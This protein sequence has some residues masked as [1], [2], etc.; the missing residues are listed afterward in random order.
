MRSKIFK[1][2]IAG[3]ATLAMAAQFAVVLPV[4]A[5]DSLYERGTTTAWS[6]ADLSDWTKTG[7]MAAPVIDASHGLYVDSNLT[8]NI[9][10]TFTVSDSAVVT[11]DVSF[12]TASS[13]GRSSNYA[14][15]KFGSNVVIG[16]NSTYNLFYNTI[17]SVA[18]TDMIATGKNAKNTTTRI[19]AVI[20]TSSNMLQSL[21]IGGTDITAAANTN[22]GSA[23]Y[24]SITMG[25]Q[26]SG[27][28]NWNTQFGLEKVNVSEVI[29]TT[30]YRNVKYEGYGPM[31]PDNLSITE[32]VVDGEKVKA[33]PSTDKAGY[34]FEGWIVDGDEGNVKT[35]SEIEDLIID[36]DYTLTAKYS[37]D[38]AYVHKI[39]SIVATPDK[40]TVQAPGT[41]SETQDISVKVTSV[42]GEDI[43][44]K[45]GMS[46]AWT[47]VGNEDDAEYTGLTKDDAKKNTLSV[48]NGMEKSYFGYVQIAATYTPAN[49]T[50]DDVTSATVKVPYA[51]LQDSASANFLP[52]QGYPVSF[53][54]YADTL[55]GYQ[56]TELGYQQKDTVFG[57]SIY[58]GNASRTLTLKKGDDGDKYFE[59]SSNGG[60]TSTVGVHQWTAQTTPY[61]VETVLKLPT[62]GDF[63]LSSNTTNNSGASN[64]KY[65][66]F[67]E[68]KAGGLEVRNNSNVA[69]NSTIAA[70]PD[71]WYKYRVIVDPVTKQYYVQLS[72]PD[73]G[74]LVGESEIVGLGDGALRLCVHG[75]VTI[76]MKSFKGYNPTLASASI[77]GTTTV[78]VPE[79]G[80]AATKTSY[81]ATVKDSEGNVIPTSPTWSLAEA[82]NGVEINE[83]TGELTVSNGA[84]GN[85]VI[86]ASAGAARAE[87][88]VL[89]T[90]SSNVVTISGSSSITIPFS[91][92][93]DVVEKYTAQTL[94]KDQKPVAD[95][96]ITY[97]LLQKDGITPY[98]NLPAGISF[99]ASTATITVKAGAPAGI[100]YVQAKNKEGLTNTV[101]VNIHGA[102]FVFGTDDAEDGYTQVLATSQYSNDAGYGFETLTGLT[103]TAKNIGGS[104]AY[105]FKAKV[106]NGNYQVVVDTTSAKMLSETVDGSSITRSAKT[107]N[108]AVC[109]G[110][111]DVTFDANS[112][113][114]LLQISQLAQPSAGAKP[115][116]YSIGDSTTK[117]AGHPTN[118]DANSTKNS[119]QTYAS[120]G[121]CVTNEMWS[122]NFASY[123]N[124]GMAG[125]NSASF[126][127]E[128]RVENVLLS[129]APGDYVTINM[130]INSERENYDLFME[131]YYV[132]G[133]LQRGGIPIILT[134]TPD[135][136]GFSN[137]GSFDSTFHV[138]R[139]V[140]TLRN[141][142]EKYNLNVIEVDKYFENY[143]NSLLE[144]DF[145]TEVFPLRNTENENGRLEGYTVPTSV[146][147]V[148]RSWY[149]DH[150]HYTREL[151]TPIATYIMSELNKIIENPF[152]IDSVTQT[153]A[154][155][156]ITLTATI[157]EGASTGSQTLGAYVAQYDANNVLVKLEK[158]DVTF[159]NSVLTAE[160]PYT[161][162]AGAANVKIILT[163]D[164]LKPYLTNTAVTVTE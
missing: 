126:Y 134:H 49:G 63:A 14:Y 82:Y 46:F 160:V 32:S 78:K 31:G 28:V 74:A 47:I 113:I 138:T 13:P 88:P 30:V 106:P 96:V 26:R 110:V 163:D 29:D 100:I 119:H 53:N 76:G 132:K 56:A 61:I 21:S 158:T 69:N 37:V 5:E 72:D 4:S 98:T 24:G 149:P 9:A 142:A 19:V 111:L 51:L 129:I 90:T 77:I 8:G 156:K 99:N 54:D 93:A 116:I 95:D 121:N 125:R 118:Y 141:L 40:T 136:P 36:K 23:T 107:F 105:T 34:T 86:V 55:L 16:Y 137:G 164:N 43:T 102:S 10:T 64:F 130:G 153:A 114:S 75:D 123:N 79:A 41:G 3:I 58:G 81:K 109:D 133:V 42:N 91:G 103:A 52:N 108:V 35:T 143:F 67:M 122:E 59:F 144:K 18:E 128:A 11:Y 25:F 145:D 104:S 45:E 150:N 139:S 33:V 152:A 57:W 27:S 89:L 20:N 7:D 73:T 151:G 97:S 48:L 87:L 162:D 2:L 6:D 131:D 135:G 85:I 70:T 140:P 62:G 115:S 12:Y 22:L 71:T 159:T 44:D 154:A 92:E 66:W 65:G 124:H 127:R 50:A 17:G 157:K 94:D 146:Y 155:D 117:N 148:V 101:K 161:K 147:E 120:W 68:M 39:A 1:K 84:G 15:V 83:N 38:T 80:E 112:T 60:G